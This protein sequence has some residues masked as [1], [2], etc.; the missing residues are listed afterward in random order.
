MPATKAPHHH[1][2]HRMRM[3]QRIKDY[4]LETL[5]EHE[6]LEYLLY[7]ALP[8]IDT[9]ELAHE[10]LDHFGGLCG[11][12]EATE[13]ELLTVKG[14]G[15]KSAELIHAVLPLARYYQV[16]KRD[17]HAELTHFEA[18]LEY[19]RPLFNGLQEEHFYMIALDD[20]G[21]PLRDI[22]L[23]KGL[24]NKVQFD[25]NAVVRQAINTRCT[26][27]LLAH[28]HPA[29]LARPSQEDHNSTIEIV[30]MLGPV[31]ITVLDHII[32]T[33]TDATSL[34]M[35]GD[36]PYF[37]KDHRLVMYEKREPPVKLTPV[38]KP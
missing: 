16:R 11:V 12:L 14:V 10:L 1:A 21:C 32:V 25:I 9:N 30:G 23:A 31:G 19:L 8:R 28:N 33:P 3:R 34:K 26:Q 22:L 15:P 38:G 29:G 13:E 37:D 20:A 6:V 5:Q 2:H 35:S 4:G 36:L 24:P 27:V 18:A 7:F 17:K